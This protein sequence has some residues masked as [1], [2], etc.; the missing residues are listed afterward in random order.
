MSLGLS[1]F[2][3][4]EERAQA[5]DRF[6][7]GEE[8]RRDRQLDAAVARLR[9]PADVSRW[10]DGVR[11]RLHEL[12]GDFPERT[13]LRPRVV[14]RIERS[15]V[16]V[17]KIILESRP[18]Y[19]VTAN[20]YLPK[21]GCARNPIARP[22]L[23]EGRAA[24]RQAAAL[25]RCHARELGRP[26]PAILIPCGHAPLG[27]GH[28]PYSQAGL[29]LARK[30]YVVMIFDPTGQGERSECINPATGRHR[31]RLTVCQHH[32]TG[33]PCL[34]T[35]TT[36]AGYR[37]WDGIRCLDYLETRSEIDPRR[38]GVMGNS[39]GGAMTMLITAVDRRV[40]VCAAS[41]PGGSCENML[42]RGY[43]PPDRDLFSLIAPRPCRIIVGDKS[44][45][46]T[47]HRIKL[48]IMKPFYAAAGCPERL[49]LV[50]VD[51]Y[52]DLLAPKREAS[53]EWFNRWFGC[54]EVGW[55][56]P[57]CRSIATRKLWC[58]AKGQVQVSLGGETMCS[59]NRARARRIGPNRV[60]PGNE[61]IWL[62]QRAPLLAALKRRLGFKR[63]T[64]ALRATSGAMQQLEGLA[65]EP[66]T[67]E[68]EPGMPISALLL[69]PNRLRGGL[70]TV[71]HAAEDGKLKAFEPGSLPGSLVR[72]GFRVLCIDVRDTGEGALCETPPF[73]DRHRKGL[74]AYMPA[75]W[76]RELLAIRALGIGRSRSGM[77][78]L[79]IIRAGDWL[80]E[81]DLIKTG[82]VVVGEGRLG[83]E[84]L[85]AAAL[86]SRVTA[87]ATVRT[88]ASY[89]F[90]TD[91]PYYNQ[92]QHFWTPGAL[93][94]Y[95]IPDLPALA[96]PRPVAFIAPVDH[97]T[98]VVGKLD[99]HRRFAW[100][101][102]AY[103][104]AGKPE[105]LVLEPETHPARIGRRVGEFLLRAVS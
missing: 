52:H 76:R 101:R 83:I 105:A 102:A 75:L 55:R 58:T 97:M 5:F 24:R 89:R 13:P 64:G 60:L 95:D 20:L 51:G 87:V 93:K 10:Q 16:I 71:V 70:P 82:F 103:T 36:L 39:G 69:T 96:A 66:V 3:T 49:E 61:T 59:L 88:L 28:L 23:A 17:E 54:E 38:I 41:H 34:L 46:E 85:K 30:G 48:D 92:Y 1:A 26:A 100:A 2:A 50:M 11:R 98:R 27:K 63:V 80:K 57:R 47:G 7:A 14:G 81:R 62:E 15:D 6:L 79:D 44:G 18:K 42:L 31:V 73:P 78:V 35:D 68:S 67:F 104:V 32:W 84:A 56:E 65:A 22:S 43:Q 29:F 25:Q 40:A 21:A 8:A 94:D 45:E 91:N 19:Y 12:L 33:K 86:D 74:C 99:L 9:T 4:P 37:T 77:R 53:C 90:I 72:Q